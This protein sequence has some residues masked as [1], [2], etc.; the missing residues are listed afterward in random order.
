MMGARAE[1]V[2]VE[3]EQPVSDCTA[4]PASESLQ[5]EVLTPAETRLA[6]VLVGVTVFLLVFIGLQAGTQFGWGWGLVVAG[7]AL[8]VIGVTVGLCACL[9]NSPR[10]GA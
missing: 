1:S 5:G 2:T 3:V 10:G 8:S 7:L 4:T 6:L 9:T